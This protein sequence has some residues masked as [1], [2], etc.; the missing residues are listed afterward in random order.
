MTNHRPRLAGA[1]PSASMHIHVHNRI[2]DLRVL[3]EKVKI[4]RNLQYT[5]IHILEMRINNL[6]SEVERKTAARETETTVRRTRR[7]RRILF[8]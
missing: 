1:I 2:L 8:V 4:L 6:I 5:G 7:R 3:L